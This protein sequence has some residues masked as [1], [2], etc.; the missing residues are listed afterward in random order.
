MKRGL[1]KKISGLLAAVILGVGTMLSS[2]LPGAEETMAAQ[3]AP[4][5]TDVSVA[6]VTA[7]GYRVTVT[8]AA[9]AGVREVLMPTWTDANWQDDLIWHQAQVNGKRASFYVSVSAHKGECGS[10]I[11]HVYVKDK[12]GNQALEGVNVAVPGK[13]Q[14]SQA[15]PAISELK[16]TELT[17]AGY[18]VTADFTAEAGVREV[19]M[20]TWTDKNG[21]DDLIWHQAEVNGNI[22]SFYVPVSA[23]KGEKGAYITHVYVKDK[24][25]RQALEGV[26]VTVPQGSSG[27][28]TQE[29]APQITSIKATEVTDTGYRVTV[30]FTASAGVREVLMPT[31]TE[32]NGQDDLIWH[33]ADVNGDTAEFYVPVSSHR[34]ESGTYITHVYVKDVNGRQAL[35]GIQTEVP[36]KQQQ[37]EEKLA[38]TKA[39]VTDVTSEGYHVRVTFTAPAGVSRVLVPTWTVTNGQDDLIWHQAQVEGNTASFYVTASAHKKETG[40]YITHVYVYDKAGNLAPLVGL[41]AVLPSASSGTQNGHT[42][43]IDAGHQRAG[44]SEKEPNGPGSSVMKAKLTSGTA[45]CVTGLAEHQLNLAVSLALKQELISRGYQVVMIRETDDCPRSNA[46][47]AVIANN[48]GAEIFVRIHA[49]SSTNS[50]VSGAMFYGPSAANPFLS[51]SVIRESN[52]LSAVMLDEFCAATGAYKRGLIQDDTMTGI[53]WCTIPVTIVEMGFMS[54]PTEDR[55]MADPSY[56][57]KMVQGLANGIDAYFGR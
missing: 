40:E 54:N 48:S 21:Q 53:N 41:G 26:N 25:G 2:I 4:Q 37:T 55:L 56:Q 22:A 7:A 42:V 27:Q 36:A 9:E 11:T 17:S 16:V 3:A 50:S 18:R 14:T 34:K 20:P 6:D 47:R 51:A 15:A 33:Q 28:Q 1:R 43:C 13:Q 31:W 35:E 23:H 8:F 30:S 45:G 39:V 49:N 46:E 19:L 12:N 57:A 5:I 44:I 32:R 29:K 38:V 52:R 24:S 10:Y